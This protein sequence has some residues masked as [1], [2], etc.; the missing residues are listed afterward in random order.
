MA[1]GRAATAGTTAL[2]PSAEPSHSPLGRAARWA[3]AHLFSSWLSTAVTLVLAYLLFGEALDR[4]TLIGAL[5]IFG[6]NIYIARREA[7]IQR[8]TVTD[9]EI[10]AEAPPPR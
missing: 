6:S 8:R 10:S 5:I 3:R 7:Q 9:P 4:Y 2:A 1:N